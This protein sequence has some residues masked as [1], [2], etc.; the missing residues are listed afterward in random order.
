MRSWQ[1]SVPDRRGFER[2]LVPRF[3]SPGDL[4]ADIQQRQHPQHQEDHG[5]NLVHQPDRHLVGELVAKQNRRRIG[6]HHAEGG[7]GNHRQHRIAEAR[8]QRH[9]GDLGLV[10]HLG[11]EEGDEGGAQDA[12]EALD[13][14][15]LLG[16]VELVGDQHP[17]GHR[18]KAQSQDPAQQAFADHV[19]DPAAERAGKAVIEQ[20]GDQDAEDDGHRLAVARGQYQRQQLR[21]VAHFC[22]G[23]DACGDEEGFHIVLWGNRAAMH[24]EMPMTQPFPGPARKGWSSVSPGMD[25]AWAVWPGGSGAAHAITASG[26]VC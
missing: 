16:V 10:T 12:D 24:R 13:R 1:P 21:L 6:D 5:R 15:R 9:R 7:A 11:K 17:R 14:T 20:R 2:G 22:E 23:D 19:R 25:A 3:F 4:S 18:D 26:Q 8:C